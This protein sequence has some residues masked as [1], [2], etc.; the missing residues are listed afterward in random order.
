MVEQIS[1]QKAK[2]I[3]LIHSNPSPNIVKNS[4]FALNKL[5]KGS[6]GQLVPRLEVLLHKHMRV[7]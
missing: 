3:G 5:A 4:Y 6:I 2:L 7:F 1:R